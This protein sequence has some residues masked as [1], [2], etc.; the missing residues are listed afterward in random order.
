MSF[1]CQNLLST[2]VPLGFAKNRN[3]KNCRTSTIHKSCHNFD[4]RMALVLSFDRTCG[5]Y[6]LYDYTQHNF[7]S[8]QCAGT[9]RKEE[10]RIRC[11]TG[12]IGTTSHDF[13]KDKRTHGYQ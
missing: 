9:T 10:E 8:S 7:L 6:Q 3:I 11:E 4:P 1:N 2:F 13:M 12:A 5:V